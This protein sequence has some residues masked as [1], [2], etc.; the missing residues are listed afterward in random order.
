M[1]KNVLLPVYSTFEEIDGD[2]LSCQFGSEGLKLLR[3]KRVNSLEMGPAYFAL[4]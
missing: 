2:E 1:V 4:P 3:R